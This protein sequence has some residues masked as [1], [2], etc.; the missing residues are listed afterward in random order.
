MN[1]QRP[2]KFFVK[3]YL[4]LL[5][6]V[7]FGCNSETSQSQKKAVLTAQS[8]F[9]DQVKINH[10]K[11]F[12]IVYHQNYK[13][14][15]I[16]NPFEKTAD[17]TRYILLE[18]GASRPAGFEKAQVIEIPVKKLVA[19][20]SMHVALL[21]FLESE[22]VITGISSPQYIY[23]PK[24][25]DMVKAGKVVDVGRDQ[26][27][28]EEKLVELHPDVV[29]AMG[30]PGANTDPYRILAQAGIPVLVNSEWVEKTPLAR[31]EWVKLMAA[32]VNQ[33]KLVNEKFDQIEA[34][35]FRLAE[36]ARKTKRKPSIL[37]GLNSKD[38][39]FLPS[40]DGYMAQFF[41]DAG[42][43][44]H[45]NA[46]KATG[47]IPLNFESVYPVAL[48]ADVWLNVGFGKNDKKAD[49][50]AQ[51][52]RYSDFKAFKSGQMYSYNARVN[53][54]GANDFFE[55]G[56]MNPHIVLADLIKVLH[57]ELLPEH[58]LVYYKQLK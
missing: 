35:Y 41:R 15:S 9:S 24:I 2:F 39:W 3:S 40:G 22:A 36:L 43:A 30:S 37:S 32:L 48:Q 33:E 46:T 38:A 45:W 54:S 8:N 21:E 1:Y 49:I 17:T 58:T 20:S 6:F 31:A 55:S 47:S 18:K 23:S 5:F 57:P 28:N 25:L 29:I 34:A 4:L 51:D 12:T 19:T 53:D 50:L 56:T 52:S 16:V 42:G 13:L 27:L 44:Y 7:L 26:G 11:G 10:A 14:V